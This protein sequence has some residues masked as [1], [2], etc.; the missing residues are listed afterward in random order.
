MISNH[1]PDLAHAE[2]RKSTHSGNGNDTCVEAARV[3][4]VVAFRDSTDPAGPALAV[5][6]AAARALA[7]QIKARE[8]DL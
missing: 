3:Q 5:T 8:H 2:W 6:P 7:R 4:D 1:F